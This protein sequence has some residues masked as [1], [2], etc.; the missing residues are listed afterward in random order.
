MEALRDA[1]ARFRIYMGHVH[2]ED[3]QE[4]ILAEVM[5]RIRRGE[6]E[7]TTFVMVY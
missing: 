3:I 4:K 1:E 2:R 7:Q 6:R 5:D